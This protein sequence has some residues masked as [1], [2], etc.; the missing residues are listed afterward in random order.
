M[1]LVVYWELE[2]SRVHPPPDQALEAFEE[3][4]GKRDGVEGFWSVIGVLSRFGD[5]DDLSPLPF[6]GGVVQVDAGLVYDLK[7]GEEFLWEMLEDEGFDAILLEPI[8]R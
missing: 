5:K 2:E 4:V 3:V 7:C 1:L 8:Q 6:L